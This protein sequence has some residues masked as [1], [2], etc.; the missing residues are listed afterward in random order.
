MEDVRETQTLESVTDDHIKKVE[1]QEALAFRRLRPE[2]ERLLDE[3]KSLDLYASE[4]KYKLQCAQLE[5]IQKK[6]EI[7]ELKSQIQN[8]NVL[9]QT[10]NN[11]SASRQP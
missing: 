6:R 3:Y 5:L 9:Y 4:M 7:K 11:A 10:V 1:K 8:Q 2:Y